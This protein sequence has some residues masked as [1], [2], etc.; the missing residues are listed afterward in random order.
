MFAPRRRH[1]TVLFWIAITALLTLNFTTHPST[2]S[3]SSALATTSS[4]LTAFGKRHHSHQTAIPSSSWI[5]PVH[6]RKL[7]SK[8]ATTFTTTTTKMSRTT[9]AATPSPAPKKRVR[10]TA[11]DGIRALLACHIVLGHFLR[12]ANPPGT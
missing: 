1:Q 6:Q 8:T 9:V 2:R 5:Y 4:S 12:Y 3:V 11:L 10:I 7:I